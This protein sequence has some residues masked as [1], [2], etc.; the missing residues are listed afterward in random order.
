VKLAY[1]NQ[2]QVLAHC[3]GD[4]AIDMMLDAHATAGAPPNRRTVIIHSQFVRPDQLDKYAEYGFMA[5]F[6]TN[7]AF[8][9][10]D[11][12]VENVGQER[13]FFLSPMRSARARGLHMTN[14]SDFV[15]TPLD[16]LFI[17]WTAV[18]RTSRSGKVI[19]PD[20]RISP[21]D[22]LRALTI[23]AAYQY[24]E[25]AT[26]GSLAPG[27][28]ADLVILSANPLTVAPTT[29][30]DIQVLETIKEGRSVYCR[31]S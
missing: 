20:E 27:K 14:H 9:W 29:I 28:V 18:N 30:K 19:G 2:I 7:H 12:H 13:A 8:F 25:E 16:P 31:A 4:A 26:K 1:D 6:F 3:N 17:M 24:R 21:H 11:V 5:S 22:A 15:V 23:D 10:G